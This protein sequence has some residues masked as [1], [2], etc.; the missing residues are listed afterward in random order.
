MTLMQ[1]DL[2]SAMEYNERKISESP[3]GALFFGIEEITKLVA[4]FQEERGLERDGKFGNKTK[5]E[6]LKA[7]SS[8]KEENLAVQAGDESKALLEVAISQLGRGEQGGNNSGTWVEMYHGKTFDGDDDDDGAWCAAFVSWCCEQV[9]GDEMPFRRSGG[10]KRLFRQIG[11]SGSFI[12]IP[13]AGDVVC[14]D[15]GKPGSWQGHI[16]I[17][18]KYENGILYTIEGNVGRFPAKVRRFKHNLENDK[19]RLEGFARLP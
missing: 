3:D 6:L 19:R 5:H 14:W 15:R 8:L 12:D 17:V 10:A 18:E 7:T 4:F 1:D 13:D 9:Y 2:L 11:G 16:G